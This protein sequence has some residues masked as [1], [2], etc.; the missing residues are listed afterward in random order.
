M[1]QDKFETKL[2]RFVINHYD[3][4]GN[5][6]AAVFLAGMIVCLLFGNST[7]LGSFTALMI[8]FAIAL[9]VLVGAPDRRRMKYWRHDQARRD[10]KKLE[11]KFVPVV[12]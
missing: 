6:I 5:T 8:G 7:I 11:Q 2:E 12:K 4:I 1:A 9:M 3:D 10:D